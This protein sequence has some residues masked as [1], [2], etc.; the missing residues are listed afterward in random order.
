MRRCAPLLKFTVVCSI[1][2]NQCTYELMTVDGWY[3]GSAIAAGRR[4]GDLNWIFWRW[5]GMRVAH[6]C[7][8]CVCVCEWRNKSSFLH[9]RLSRMNWMHSYDEIQFSNIFLLLL[10]T[11]EKNSFDCSLVLSSP[12]NEFTF[13]GLL[14]SHCNM[15]YEQFNSFSDRL[16]RTTKEINMMG[17]CSG[18]GR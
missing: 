13:I 12:A 5:I 7:S 18:F 2:W 10:S 11:Q 4:R 9:K 14:N 3:D 16:K 17:T 15:I 1:Y 6:I 8:S